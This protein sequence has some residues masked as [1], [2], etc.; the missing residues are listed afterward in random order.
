MRGV[1]LVVGVSAGIACQSLV[2]IED[3]T[4]GPAGGPDA[5]TGGAAGSATGGSGG[6]GASGGQ[7]GSGGIGGTAGD[8]GADAPL[9]DFTFNVLPISIDLPLD[10]IQLVPVQITRGSGFTSAVTVDATATSGL[11]WKTLTLS[12]SETTGEVELSA[13]APLAIGNTFNLDFTATGGGKTHGDSTAVTIVNKPGTLDTTFGNGT[14]IARMNTG[15]TDGSVWLDIAVLPDDRIAGAGYQVLLSSAAILGMV[16]ADGS[17]WDTSFASNGHTGVKLCA[18]CSPNSVSTGI[19]ISPNTSNLVPTANRSGQLGLA[20][21]KLDGNL[22]ATFYG[23]GPGF[24][25][26]DIGGGFVES[27]GIIAYTDQSTLRYL[28]NGTN[29]NNDAWVAE[30]DGP[31]GF[32]NSFGGSNTGWVQLGMN[33]ATH[34]TMA[35][36]PGGRIYVAGTI[37]DSGTVADVQLMALTKDGAPDNA[38]DGDGKISFGSPGV[39]DIP[40]AVAVQPDGKVLVA[41]DSVTDLWVAR[42][43][44]TGT[45]DAS[46]G[47]AGMATLADSGAIKVVD[48]VVQKDGRILVAANASAAPKTVVARFRADGTP[49]ATWGDGG[50]LHID[51]GPESKLAAIKLQSTGKI[52][53]AGEVGNAPSYEPWTMVARLWP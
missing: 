35:R 19:A 5:S 43:D 15:A 16:K 3:T 41:G 2:G 28:L 30:M 11:S 8:A 46:F 14:G 51:L 53:V 29:G 47:S 45:A 37:L 12:P 22:D 34:S 26:E 9:A 10:G 20:V 7:A 50:L 23:T 18:S 40:A 39:E 32:H 48:M 42:F 49:D 1:L 31:G 33:R 17:G 4:E 13:T 21:Y 6:T 38:F 27:G 52:L 25:L 44:A 36:D 24:A